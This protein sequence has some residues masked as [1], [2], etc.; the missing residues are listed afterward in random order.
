MDVWKEEGRLI[1]T[2]SKLE[3]NRLPEV[4]VE[5]QDEKLKLDRDRNGQNLR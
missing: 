1:C 2:M 5:M 3:E 4:E